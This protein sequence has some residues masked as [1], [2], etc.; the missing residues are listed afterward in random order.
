M[1]G[2]QVRLRLKQNMGL[3]A[4][5][6]LLLINVYNYLFIRIFNTRMAVHLQ[7]TIT[8]LTAAMDGDSFN[9]MLA[10]L[11]AAGPINS[12]NNLLIC[13]Q[14]D[15]AVSRRI[16]IKCGVDESGAIS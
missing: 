7:I 4:S 10:P 15:F 12:S 6:E 14:K 11:S 2:W 5:S 16:N 3:I 8:W 13:E 9:I 1:Q